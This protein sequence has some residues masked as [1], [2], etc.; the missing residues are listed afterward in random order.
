MKS[1]PTPTALSRAQYFGLFLAV[2]AAAAGTQALV[3]LHPQLEAEYDIDVVS[4]RGLTAVY[5]IGYGVAGLLL[6]P[7]AARFGKARLLR[8]MLVVFAIAN[9]VLFCG[10]PLWAFYALRLLSGAAAGALFASLQVVIADAVPFERRGRALAIVMAGSFVAAILVLWASTRL[11][12]FGVF[13]V[14]ALIA[15]CALFSFA[16][17]PRRSSGGAEPAR[18]GAAALSRDRRVLAALGVTALNTLA[19]FAVIGSFAGHLDQQFA[20]TPAQKET[21]FL[22]LGLASLPGV[23]L[24]ATLSDRLGKRRSVAIALAASLA[25]SPAL[26]ATDS[27]QAFVVCGG[28]LA[29]CSALRQGPFAALLTQLVDSRQR[30]RLLGWNGFASGIGIAL[31]QLLGGFAHERGGFLAAVTVSAVALV[32]SLVLLLQVRVDE[33]PKRVLPAGG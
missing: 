4:A 5:T 21:F 28:V 32:G 23:F 18:V 10:P 19:A 12:R 27:F 16:L 20:V 26:V 24:A 2:F 14:F 15:V 22:V 7:L 13:S 11:S 30:P 33:S 6:G 1:S 3:S 29:A 9:A 17:A 8:R 25:L 31:G